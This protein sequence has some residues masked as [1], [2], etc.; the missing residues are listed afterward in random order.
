[1]D[2]RNIPETLTWLIAVFNQYNVKYQLSGGCAAH[3]YGASRMINDID[4]D[5]LNESLNGKQL[6]FY[7]PSMKLAIEYCGLWYHS[8]LFGYVDR[9]THKN[10][11][12]ECKKLGIRLITIFE[13]E[14]LSK[15]NICKGEGNFYSI[16]GFDFVSYTDSGYW[17]FG[18]G[19]TKYQRIHRSLF[20]KH[21]LLEKMPDVDVSLSE[22]D[23]MKMNG[24]NRIW[25]CGNS[26]YVWRIK[27][28]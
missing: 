18:K 6:D 9:K 21:K 15:Q 10:K 27:N 11:Y 20:M 4:I 17:Y 1:M 12:F 28:E 24:W 22:W 23:I 3:I 5:I 2:Y 8:E 25:D 14:W 7:I 13:D 26:K 16:L 19:E